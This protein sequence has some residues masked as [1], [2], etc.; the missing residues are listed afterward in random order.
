[1]KIRA[2]PS[3]ATG[4]YK[5]ERTQAWARAIFEDQPVLGRRINGVLYTAAHSG[6]RSLALWN[7]DGVVEVVKSDNGDL[8]DFAL[9]DPAMWT[10]ALTAADDIE[11]TL[12]RIG[13]DDCPDCR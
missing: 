10:R 13:S 1:M 12:S 3:L 8:Q 5:Y 4:A 6:G 9:L 11:V 2:L 7:T